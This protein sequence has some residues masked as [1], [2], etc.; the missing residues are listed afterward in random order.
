QY[1]QNNPGDFWQENPG[2]TAWAITRPFAWASWGSVGDWCGYSGDPTS[3]DYGEDVYYEDDQ[4]YS[5]DQPI[6]TE[7]EYAQQAEEIATTEP[8]SEP[9][10]GDCLP[11]GVFAITQDGQATGAEPTIYMQLAISKQGAISGTLK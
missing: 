3:Y 6:A 11:L 8:A 7:E 10:Q 4:V 2:W 5:G 9:A 1:D